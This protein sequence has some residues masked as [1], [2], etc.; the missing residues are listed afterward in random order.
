MCYNFFMIKKAYI[1]CGGFGTRLNLPFPK[2]LAKIH[3]KTLLEIQV[4]FLRN[5]GIFDIVNKVKPGAK[6]LTANI[7]PQT[8]VVKPS[9]STFNSVSSGSFSASGV[10]G[11]Y[12]ANTSYTFNY[13]F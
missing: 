11:G 6:P 2:V 9:T 10:G 4:N 1:I 12:G 13:K 5:S 7:Y 8:T 3:D